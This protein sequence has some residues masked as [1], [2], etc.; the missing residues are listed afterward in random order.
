MNRPIRSQ[1]AVR[2]L[3]LEAGELVMVAGALAR[4]VGVHGAE[5]IHVQRVGTNEFEWISADAISAPQP[6]RA[7]RPVRHTTCASAED[8]ARARD[9]VTAFRQAAKRSDGHLSKSY[10]RTLADRFET[11]I[12]TVRR[13]WKRYCE[14]PNASAQLACI[15]GPAPGSRMLPPVV[16]SLIERAIS[17]VYLT[18]EERPITRAHLRCRELAKEANLTPPSYQSVRVRA[19]SRDPLVLARKRLGSHEGNAKQAPSIR[20]LSVTRPLQVVQIDHALIDLIVVSPVSKKPIGRPWITVAIDV[21]TRCVVGYFLSFDNPTQTSVAHALE[22]ACFP[23]STWLGDLDLV[24]LQYPMF[25]KMEEIH[26]DNAKNFKAAAIIAQCERHNI[27]IPHRP[28]RCP[29]YG[30]YI[31]RLIG[32]MMGACHLLPGTTKSNSKARGDYPSE[33]KAIFTFRDLERWL[34]AEIIGVYHNS[35]HRGLSGRTPAKAWEEAW[36]TSDGKHRLPQLVGNRREFVLGMLPFV[37]RKVVRT[38]IHINGLTYWDPAISPFINSGREYTIHFSQRD[39]SRVFLYTQDGFLD[40]PLQDRTQ[41][42]FSLW[43]LREVRR[44]L[45][46]TGATANGEKELFAALAQQ[47]QIAEAAETTSKAA[48]RKL[49]RMPKAQKKPLPEV[50]YTETLDP[51]PHHLVEVQ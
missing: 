15:P 45:R 47:R 40:V 30:A 20:G 21:F 13:R 9:W 39:L 41:D 33:R 36:A 37:N 1:Q 18:R 23:K 31:E 42:P 8:E 25:G 19:L 10:C 46:A 6:E 7:R 32:T 16:E 44:H 34:A 51:L 48:R 29:H 11:S 24:D 35:P 2:D 43:E 49:A 26:W 5:K 4:I 27:H 12:R 14:N 28:A 50:D 17:E 22:H 3:R 38:G